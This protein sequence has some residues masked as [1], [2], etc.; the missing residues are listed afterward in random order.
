MA[1]DLV[2]H[3]D[4]SVRPGGPG[5]PYQVLESFLV[6]VSDATSE[7][8][9][10]FG[11]AVFLYRGCGR[12]AWEAALAC[13]NLWLGRHEETACKVSLETWLCGCSARSIRQAS[14]VGGCLRVLLC[15]PEGWT[16]LRESKVRILVDTPEVVSLESAPGVDEDSSVTLLEWSDSQISRFARQGDLFG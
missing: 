2:L 11:G 15:G 6:A 1:E 5:E 14:R 3:V 16:N 4:V 10:R 9:R 7:G 12:T 13:L 8:F